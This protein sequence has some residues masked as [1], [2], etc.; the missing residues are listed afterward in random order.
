MKILKVTKTKKREGK[1]LYVHFEHEDPLSMIFKR[2]AEIRNNDLKISN[3]I[4]PHFFARYNQLQLQCK[5]AREKDKDLRTKI[6][7]GI[8]DLILSTKKVNEP[9]YKV[10]DI[11]IFRELPNFNNELMWPNDKVITMTTPPKGR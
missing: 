8:S 1:I 5:E 2:S 4:A 11:N 7:L 6:T 3:Y 9:S 10:Q